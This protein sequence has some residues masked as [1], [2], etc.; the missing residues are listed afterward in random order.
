MIQIGNDRIPVAPQKKE[1]DI[2]EKENDETMM[3]E[4]IPSEIIIIRKKQTAPLANL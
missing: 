2:I 4:A 1:I 3:N